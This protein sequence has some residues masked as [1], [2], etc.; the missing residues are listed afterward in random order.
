M[1]RFFALS[2]VLATSSLLFAGAGAAASAATTVSTTAGI[3]MLRVTA[4]AHASGLPTISSNWSGYAVTS[5]LKFTYVHSEFVQ[6]AIKCPGVKNQ[7]TSN[8][9]GLDGFADETVEQDGTAAWCGGKTFTTPEYAAWYEMYPAGS[10]NVFK[11]NPGDLIEASVSATTAGKFSLT[12]SDLTTNKSVVHHATCT[13][14][15]LASAEWII[16]RPAT[17]NST[18]TRCFLFALANFGESTM[19]E[20][21]AQVAGGAMKGINKFENYPIAMI[22]PLKRGFVS[23]DTVGSVTPST[24]SF[25]A[26]WDRAGTITPITL[27]RDLLVSK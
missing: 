18:G 2:A 21:Y 19:S 7:Q 15:A 24:S 9:V 14:C 12:V 6:P 16:E 8:W 17:C 23:L 13:K 25:T 5:K 1:K 22:D 3:P 4:G 27:G 11:V 10:M 20:D 26:T